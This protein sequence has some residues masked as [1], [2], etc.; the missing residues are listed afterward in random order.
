MIQAEAHAGKTYYT[1]VSR[2]V[3]YSATQLAGKWFVAS[4]RLALGR[5]N[6]GGGK[7]YDTL[8]DVSKGCKALAGI[9]VLVAA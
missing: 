2:G 3:Q 1:A 5:S 9:D 8:A 6:A 7:Y 4:R